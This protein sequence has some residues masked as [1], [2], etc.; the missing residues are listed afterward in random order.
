ML[1]YQIMVLANVYKYCLIGA[2]VMLQVEVL[3]AYDSKKDNSI[4]LMSSAERRLLSFKDI[5]VYAD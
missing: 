1:K 3:A 4:S 5:F 2:C